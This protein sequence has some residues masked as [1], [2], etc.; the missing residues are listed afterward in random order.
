MFKQREGQGMK[1]GIENLGKDTKA[2]ATQMQKIS[3]SLDALLREVSQ[4]QYEEF[5]EWLLQNGTTRLDLAGKATQGINLSHLGYALCGSAVTTL[6]VRYKRIGDTGVTDLVKALQN[7]QITALYLSGNQI[8]ARG[9]KDLG[10]AL[11]DTDVT[12]L[13]LGF[14]QIGAGAA[15]L[16]KALRKTK[17]T[18]LSLV[19]NQISD[20]RAKDLGSALQGTQITTLY[21]LNNDISDRGAMDL[22][23]ALQNTKVTTLNLKYNPITAQGIDAFAA[24]VEGTCLLAVKFGPEL[25]HQGLKQA[26]KLNYQKIVL[27]PYYAACL[28][29][30]PK[31][32]KEQY[33][34]LPQLCAVPTVEE[35]C[36]YAGGI[37]MNEGL[38]QELCEYILSFL[39]LMNTKV[40]RTPLQ[41]GKVRAQLYRQKAY[42]RHSVGLQIGY[43]QD[44]QDRETTEKRF[45]SHRAS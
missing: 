21:L 43:E 2:I 10:I 25:K 29:Y 45:K 40:S 38:P 22:V 18:T 41:D 12:E 42:T 30:L 1:H 35:Q 6:N 9:A 33:Q 8:S 4:G 28:R 16:V 17:V 34:N 37:L 3:K 31:K 27:T 14:N 13:R 24:L 44:L 36:R 19:F 39:P 5:R 20:A 11:Q 26:L 32:E 7:T 23:K 15:D